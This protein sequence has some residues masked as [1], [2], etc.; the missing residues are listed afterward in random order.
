[1]KRLTAANE[2]QQAKKE[3][4]KVLEEVQSV[5]EL[6]SPEDQARSA[7]PTPPRNRAAISRVDGLFSFQ[8]KTGSSG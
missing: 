2:T 7:T 6:V 4:H 1:M 3:I 5:V 8:S